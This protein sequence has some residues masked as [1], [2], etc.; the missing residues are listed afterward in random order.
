M[1]SDIYVDI[2]NLTETMFYREHFKKIFEPYPIPWCGNPLQTDSFRR[3]V[4]DSPEYLWKLSTDGKSTHQGIRRN[5]VTL[6]SGN[7]V[8]YYLLVSFIQ[9]RFEF[10]YKICLMCL[11]RFYTLLNVFATDKTFT[12]NFCSRN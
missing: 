5:S 10:F 4:G 12:A 7:Y 3:C 6:R 8:W 2:L 9:Y 11:I 1:T